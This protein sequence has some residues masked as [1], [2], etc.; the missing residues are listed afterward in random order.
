[1][2][3]N[4][5]RALLAEGHE[6]ILLLNM[7]MADYARF[8]STDCRLL[9]GGAKLRS[10][11]VD[12]LCTGQKLKE[13]DFL[14]R[15]T[16]EAYRYD[17]A[18]RQVYELEKPDITE[19]VDY[20]GP[21]YY[22]LNAKL[23]GLSFQETRPVVRLHGP[24]ELIDQS[25]AYQAMDFD[26]FTAYALERQCF[27]LAEATLYATPSFLEAYYDR[28][29]EPGLGKAVRR[30]AADWQF[31]NPSLGSAGGEYHAVLWASVRLERPRAV[32]GCRPEPAGEPTGERL[33]VLPG[34]LRFEPTAG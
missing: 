19:F 27:R 29:S 7:S 3:F 5:A 20:C 22:A 32:C 28:Q 23:C 34:G 13:S 8:T 6:V 14:S 25:T 1:M 15:Y 18:C 17:Y 2:G 12:A 21:A 9:D 16:W 30:P 33:A 31:P 26:R 10:Y 4:L 11:H 24:L